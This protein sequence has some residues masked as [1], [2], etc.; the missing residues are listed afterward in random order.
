MST[1]PVADEHFEATLRSFMALE[2]ERAA[3]AAPPVSSV[4]WR[5]EAISARATRPGR[6]AGP[7]GLGS[8]FG[9]LP[10]PV[11]CLLV[12]GV[13]AALVLGASLV[14]SGIRGPQPTPAPSPV[15]AISVTYT[16]GEVL[17]P[18]ISYAVNLGSPPQVG[19][20]FTIPQTPY[21]GAWSAYD[22]WGP[23]ELMFSGRSGSFELAL[24][25]DV[26][27]D[28]CHRQSGTAGVGSTAYAFITAMVNSV[29]SIPG[30]SITTLPAADVGGNPAL[31][32][33]IRVDD[34]QA[35]EGCDLHDALLW[36]LPSD[37][38]GIRT[39]HPAMGGGGSPGDLIPGDPVTL[40]VADANGRPGII[41]PMVNETTSAQTIFGELLHSLHWTA[42]LEG[43]RQYPLAPTSTKGPGLAG[44]PLLPYDYLLPG[45]R[46]V[47][48]VGSEPQIDLDVTL[49]PPMQWRY[50]GSESARG[51]SASSG[52]GAGAFGVSVEIP[53]FIHPRPCTWLTDMGSVARLQDLGSS[54]D[55]LV[56][57]LDDALNQVPGMLVSSP[58]E[59]TIGGLPARLLVA[60]LAW[61][62]PGQTDLGACD[63]LTAIPWT[64]PSGVSYFQIINAG[65]YQFYVVNVHGTRAIVAAWFATSAPGPADTVAS[66]LAALHFH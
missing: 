28:A 59:A 3:D 41:V 37:V 50:G 55:D 31:A 24:P 57:R 13:L 21:A 6:N 2:A 11:R 33:T 26:Y 40:L 53:N 20:I 47:I 29:S 64:V 44:G 1:Q 60:T 22:D 7:R 42:P 62:A 12:L 32:V 17:E 19:A 51:L 34:A 43:S 8:A 15:S 49:P 48:S 27:L 52:A 58:K 54:A 63:Q 35:L 18:G 16:T 66:V 36:H 30:V 61:R 5:L 56:F 65:T 4:L 14:G 23:D 39:T 45:E 25:D 38:D 10:L 46:Y 9:A